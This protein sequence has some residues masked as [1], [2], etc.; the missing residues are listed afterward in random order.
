MRQQRGKPETGQ[1]L[2]KVRREGSEVIV[3]V[4]DDGGGLDLAAIRRKAYEKGLLAENQKLTDEQAVELILQPGFST[5]SELTHAAGRGVGMDVV[6]NEIK[7]LGGSMR[8][9]TRTGEGTRFLIRLPYT[10]AITHALIVNV[11]EETF[12]LPL[13]TVEGITRLSRDKILQAPDRGRAEARLR[14]HRLSRSSISAASSA[15]RLRRCR[16]TRARCRSC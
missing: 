6:D 14:R 1:V 9:E 16:R 11:G 10:L 15:P 7:K 4:K 13:P 5:A 2:L 8:I 3:E 12:A